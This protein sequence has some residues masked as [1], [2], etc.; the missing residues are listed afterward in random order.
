MHERLRL[1]VWSQSGGGSTVCAWIR[2]RGLMG[3]FCFNHHR[4]THGGGRGSPVGVVSA[5]TKTSR[6]NIM[7][8]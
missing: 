6:G 3:W 1:V 2:S 8:R 7:H 4:L 5:P